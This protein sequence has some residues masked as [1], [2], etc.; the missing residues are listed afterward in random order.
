MLVSN[1]MLSHVNITA[2]AKT[3]D[4]YDAQGIEIIDSNLTGSNTTANTL[5]L[6]NAEVTV[7]NSAVSTGLV[8]LGGLAIPPTNNTLAFFN[9]QAAVE[10]TNM[11]GSGS[12]MLGGSTLTFAQGPVSVSNY[13]NAASASTLVLLSGTNTFDGAPTGPGLLSIILANSSGLAFNQTG[14]DWGSTNAAFDAGASGTINNHSISG[15][16]IALGALSG[17]AGST[18]QG[19]DQA[20]P[21]LDTYVVGGLGS[22]TTFAGTITD[23]T[24]GAT[25][26]TVAL[27]KVGSGSFTLAGANGYSGGTTVSNGTLLVNNT[28]GSGTGGGGVSVVGGATLGGSGVIGGPVIVNGN[29]MPRQQWGGH[30]DDQQQSGGQRRG[31]AAIRV[32]HQRL[33]DSGDRQ[34][35]FG[36]HARPQRCGGPDHGRVPARDVQWRVDLQWRDDRHDAYR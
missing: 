14:S 6:Y 9:A 26:H 7:T 3:F 12:I 19:S 21:G 33:P 22:N 1:V 24:G 34:S 23:G 8:T 35:D 28:T 5:T 11:L 2:P 13:L 15:V 25:P 4:I 10:D 36:W 16:A 32:G 30:P 20:G 31:G 27:T 17:G 18:L 29:L